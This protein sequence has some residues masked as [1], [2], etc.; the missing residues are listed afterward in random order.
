MAIQLSGS[1]HAH[2]HPAPSELL[3]GVG[4]IIVLLSLLMVWWHWHAIKTAREVSIHSR[5]P[6]S[7]SCSCNRVYKRHT[8]FFFF[9]SMSCMDLIHWQRWITVGYQCDYKKDHQVQSVVQH[10]PPL[11]RSCK[12]FL[13]LSMS[14]C[15]PWFYKKGAFHKP[16]VEECFSHFRT[17]CWCWPKI[18]L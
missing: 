1:T 13:K 17:F 4:V 7:P 14:L 18:Y 15:S 16:H 2:Y 10:P 6:G 12:T 9:W 3:L 11:P 8:F 5:K